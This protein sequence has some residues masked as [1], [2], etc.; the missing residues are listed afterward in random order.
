MLSISNNGFKMVQVFQLNQVVKA[1]RPECQRVLAQ[2]LILLCL[3][4]SFAAVQMTMASWRKKL[5]KILRD[6]VENF[7]SKKPSVNN[8]GFY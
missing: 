5:R 7:A 2:S 1:T 8:I 4:A 6:H 3:G